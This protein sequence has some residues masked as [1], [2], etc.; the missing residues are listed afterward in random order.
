MPSKF[1]VKYDLVRKRINRKKINKPVEEPRFGPCRTL[2]SDIEKKIVCVLKSK[3]E[4]GLPLSVGE[5]LPTINELIQ[6]ENLQSQIK[7]IQTR[8]HGR[9]TNDPMIGKLGEGWFRNFCQRY[10]DEIKSKKG[11]Q[12][13][14]Y[15]SNFTTFSNFR[16]MYEN[17]ENSM[18]RCGVAERR[19]VPV[20][21]NDFG[22]IV[23]ELEATG[24]K[25]STNLTHPELCF[26]FDEVGCNTSMAKDGNVAGRRYMCAAQN[27]QRIIGSKKDKHFTV[28]GVTAFDG[29]PVMCVVI[30]DGKERNLL[31][32]VGIDLDTVTLD[33]NGKD[34]VYPANLDEDFII[35]NFGHGKRFP[36]GPV[37][38]YKDTEVPCMVRFNN[39]GGINTNILTDILRGLDQLHIFDEARNTG[40]RPFLLVDGHGSRFGLEFLKYIHTDE[41][42]WTVCLGVPYG[43]AHWQVGDSS[44]QNGKWKVELSRRK[45][46]LIDR[47][48]ALGQTTLEIL[49]TDI[50]PLVNYA[51]DRS[52]A[53]TSNNKKAIAERGWNPLNRSLLL[54]SEIRC[55]MTEIDYEN[56][57]QSNFPP[58]NRLK[59]ESFTNVNTTERNNNHTYLDFSRP[60]SSRVLV[61]IA[62]HTDLQEARRVRDSEIE[63]GKTIKKQLIDL[64]NIT[65]GKLVKDLRQNELDLGVLQVL[66]ARKKERMKKE[67][68]DESKHLELQRKHLAKLNNVMKRQ[69]DAKK[70]TKS[71]LYTVL[72]ALKRKGDKVSLSKLLKDNKIEEMQELWIRWRHRVSELKEFVDL[73]SREVVV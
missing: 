45:K 64:P 70:I 13:D 16:L 38:R 7:F 33:G 40:I 52:F 54:N 17:V 51:W 48:I 63:Q 61:D 31:T 25:S 35:N 57:N 65:A 41:H 59:Q 23:D 62:R 3:S 26:A 21:V 14:V 69:S 12:F 53:L 68:E 44:E 72:A 30:I 29:T 4:I 43:T 1:D 47:R 49:P 34:L 10:K 66:D 15:R 28:I 36:G 27:Q 71:E 55:T 5:C 56:E 18:I 42:L 6:D 8:V 67:K 2:N 22:E 39:G 73:Y 46:Y 37:C 50:L 58:Y 11:R 32:E 20:Y 60:L 9:C 24:Y 19:D